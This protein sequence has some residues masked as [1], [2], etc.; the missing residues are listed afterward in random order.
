MLSPCYQTTA[1]IHKRRIQHMQYSLLKEINSKTMGAYLSAREYRKLYWPIFF[2]L[3]YTPFLTYETLVGS[4][5]NPVAADVVAY[6]S[7]AP[8]KTRKTVSKLTGDIPA[9]RIKKIMK[10]T[11]IN[12]YNILRAQ[13]T[14]DQEALLELVFGDVDA[15]VEGVNARLEW[16]ALQGLS[17]GKITLNK[18][19]N[20]GIVT[21]SD[22]DFQ[23]P[24][25][26][27]EVCAAANR[28]WT[29]ANS[30]TALPI[31]DIETVVEEARAAGVVIK[32]VLM[33]R[34]KWLAV[35]VNDEATDFF[36]GQMIV[37]SGITRTS[38]RPSLKAF[39]QALE[40]NGFPKIIVIDSYISIE[41]E[42]HDITNVDPWEDASGSD[43]YVT[44]IPD[45][46]L[47]SM[48]YGPIAEETNPPKQVTQAK[49]GPILVSK[50]SEVDPVQEFTK[51]E[52]NAFPSWPTVDSCW[53]LDTESH[54]TFGA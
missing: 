17:R 53:I 19:V 27:K 26:N 28:Y 36:Y 4:K 12:T 24:S 43:R 50:W 32:Y 16:L 23:I 7:S 37:D 54:T 2:P 18:T 49:K 6:N 33:N 30:A 31:T 40:D 3:K 13:A 5:G 41:N 11:D 20:A 47:G 48:L 9:T 25:A 45:L 22:I 51:G 46:V 29:T 42:S 1:D 39:N 35:K 10:E 44:F 8:E 38:L 52:I 34:S 21:E 15:V 14:P